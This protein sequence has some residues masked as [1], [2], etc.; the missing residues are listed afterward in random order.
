[1]TAYRSIRLSG[2]VIFLLLANV[3]KASLKRL[4]GP[5]PVR[6]VTLSPFAFV[7]GSCTGTRWFSDIIAQK[8]NNGLFLPRRRKKSFYLFVF[9]ST[10]LSV[11]SKN[12]PAAHPPSFT[13]LPSSDSDAVW[14]WSIIKGD[15]ICNGWCTFNCGRLSS[16]FWVRR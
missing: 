5:F 6:S 13:S 9:Q 2:W 8:T 1:M 11:L 3:P 12:T 15:E 7:S 16:C 14:V 4:S 10:N